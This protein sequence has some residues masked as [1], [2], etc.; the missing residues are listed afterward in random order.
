MTYASPTAPRYEYR[1]HLPHYQ[2][3]D[4]PIFITFCKRTH[5]PF[6]K[7]ARDIII[8]CCLRGH[9]KKFL[10]HAAVIM[11]DHVHLLL[12][13]LRDSNGWPYLLPHILKLIKGASARAINKK[14]QRTGQVWQHESFDHILRSEESQAAKQ[15]YIRQNSVRKGLVREP[16]DYPW[17]WQE[18]KPV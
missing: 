2:K 8:G 15:E 1:R 4:W 18:P 6:S 7:E 5:A 10:L 16:E 12:T 3:S 11:P 17:F 9:R 13:P 14:A